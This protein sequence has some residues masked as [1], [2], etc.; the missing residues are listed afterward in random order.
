VATEQ[1]LINLYLM[2][3]KNAPD[4]Y[5]VL[6]NSMAE[7]PGAQGKFL[8]CIIEKNSLPNK[9]ASQCRPYRILVVDL[10]SNNHYFINDLLFHY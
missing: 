10:K 3:I 6:K 5:H 1:F 9:G 8:R 4:L 7:S 2:I